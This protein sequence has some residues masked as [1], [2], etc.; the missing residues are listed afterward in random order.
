MSNQ[1]A[2]TTATVTSVRI[3]GSA[4]LPEEGAEH[5]RRKLTLEI[6]P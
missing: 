2:V 3:L 1:L 5:L 6:S 4:L